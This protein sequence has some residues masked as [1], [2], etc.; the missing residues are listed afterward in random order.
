[1]SFSGFYPI[2]YITAHRDPRE[3]EEVLSPA[4]TAIAQDVDPDTGKVTAI[5]IHDE[6]WLCTSPDKGQAH[7]LFTL[8]DVDLDCLRE[9]IDTGLYQVA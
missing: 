7:L 3:A 5:Q 9:A 4:E 8:N 6:E 2:E 1:M